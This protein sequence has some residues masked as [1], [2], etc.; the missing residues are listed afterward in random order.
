MTG[1]G[2]GRGRTGVGCIEGILGWQLR[3]SGNAG[4]LQASHSTAACAGHGAATWRTLG[5]RTSISA[6]GRQARRVHAGV[7]GHAVGN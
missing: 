2:Q 4:H 5:N 6:A 3:V 7:A 1:W